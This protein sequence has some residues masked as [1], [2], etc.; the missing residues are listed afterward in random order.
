M[1]SMAMLWVSISAKLIELDTV[2][3]HRESFEPDIGVRAAYQKKEHGSN[4]SARFK[5]NTKRPTLNLDNFD[6]I[7]EVDCREDLVNITFDSPDNAQSAY[8]AWKNISHLAV[9]LGHE[10]RCKGIGNVSTLAVEKVLEPKDTMLTIDTIV[11]KYDQLFDG[12]EVFINRRP[13]KETRRSKVREFVK[14]HKFDLNYNRTTQAVIKEDKKLLQISAGIDLNSGYTEIHCWHCYLTGDLNISLHIQSKFGRVEA[15]KLWVNGEITANLDLDVF[16]LATTFK[17]LLQF[18]IASLPLTPFFVPGLFELGPSIR[19]D[20]GVDIRVLQTL[21]IGLGY[22]Y[23]HKFEFFA[24]GTDLA[25][26]PKTTYSGKPVVNAHKVKLDV[27]TDLYAVAYILPY[28]SLGARFEGE[29]VSMNLGLGNSISAK[30]SAGVGHD[31]AKGRY[32]LALV[33]Q[34]DVEF[35]IES[36]VHYYWFGIYSTGDINLFCA[37]CNMCL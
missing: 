34:H 33:K 19:L 2:P 20:V 7:K 27:E 15:Y 37:F 3:I 10:H 14:T 9:M 1:L 24:E 28:I 6:Q 13:H 18:N 21:G 35:W 17:P 8:R 5:W 23:K 12:F 30:V 16:L 22:D 32:N 29:Q 36:F 4:I 11:L 31:C 26:K 25:S